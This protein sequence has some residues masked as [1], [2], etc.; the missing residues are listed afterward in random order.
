M[1]ARFSINSKETVLSGL[2]R[3]VR[4]AAIG[5]T[6]ELWLTQGKLLRPR[7]MP[8]QSGGSGGGRG[9]A[10]GRAGD[11]C[12]HEQVW[13]E[14]GEPAAA[15]RDQ[16][17]RFSA[18]LKALAAGQDP[19]ALGGAAVLMATHLFGL[20][21]LRPHLLALGGGGIGHGGWAATRG[22]EQQGWEHA[23]QTPA[24]F[25]EPGRAVEALLSALEQLRVAACLALQQA[26]RVDAH[27][28]LLMCAPLPAEATVEDL[29]NLLTLERPLEGAARRI[30]PLEGLNFV[31]TEGESNASTLACRR[32][33][34]LEVP[35]F[36]RATVVTELL[37]SGLCVLAEVGEKACE[38]VLKAMECPGEVLCRVSGI[39][40]V[41]LRAGDKWI[42]RRPDGR[43]SSTITFGTQAEAEQ[44]EVDTGRRAIPAGPVLHALA[45]A[46][47]A[48]SCASQE[49]CSK[50]AARHLQQRG[51][52]AYR[53]TVRKL[54]EDP[55][56]ACFAS[57]LRAMLHWLAQELTPA[58][59]RQLMWPAFGPGGGAGEA[60]RLGCVLVCCACDG[61]VCTVNGTT[62]GSDFA[63][64]APFPAFLPP[65]TVAV[66]CSVAVQYSGDVRPQRE[67]DFGREA[68][69]AAG[70]GGSAASGP[71]GGR[72]I[73]DH[74]G[75]A[76]HGN[77]GT[78]GLVG[79]VGGQACG[80]GGRSR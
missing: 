45:A 66:F 37:S 13:H 19:A 67:P 15:A 10:G 32:L 36:P 6:F 21:Q 14:V 80:A 49:A 17:A 65:A 78:L 56:A 23:L 47:A 64:P 51:R 18:A 61:R 20:P 31:A 79:S 12:W 9:G 71:A 26:G 22:Q 55:A 27:G 38:V 48:I 35:Y 63:A 4:G 53:T 58:R 25:A 62:P 8:Q 40:G 73:E 75:G 11:P 59:M 76:G 43:G 44:Y 2:Q 30:M 33:L 28:G 16:H 54:L 72:P 1:V 42:A 52:N 41:T 57:P 34:V 7:V 60:L 24:T 74:G 50:A 39:P 29:L 5:D 69:A 68:S 3:A 46:A 77:A 70:G